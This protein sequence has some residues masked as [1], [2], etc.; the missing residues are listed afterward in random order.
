MRGILPCHLPMAMPKKTSF[1]QIT[2]GIHTDC[3]LNYEMVKSFNGE[4]YKGEHYCDSI[5]NYHVSTLCVC[6]HLSTAF[7]QTIG[8][9]VESMIVA[10][11]IVDH[12]LDP[13]YF[14]FFV[15]YLA[16]VSRSQITFE[17]SK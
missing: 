3:L 9:L 6:T 5:K 17:Q 8:L 1:S 7:F 4:E 13:S 15:A 10:Q 12:E 11:Q 2:R 16:Q 14:V